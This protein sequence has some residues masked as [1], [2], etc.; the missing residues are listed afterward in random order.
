MFLKKLDIFGV[1]ICILGGKKSD[2]KNVTSEVREEFSQG[3]NQSGHDQP[4]SRDRARRM[5]VTPF[6]SKTR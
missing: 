6:G 2:I 5:V 3:F 4:S 1:N